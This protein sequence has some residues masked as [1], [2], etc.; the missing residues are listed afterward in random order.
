MEEEE[1]GVEV[2]TYVG[3]R[4]RRL[5]D[6]DDVWGRRLGLD[7]RRWTQIPGRLVDSLL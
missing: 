6:G 1:E 5:G 2:S 7:S 4:V 3:W